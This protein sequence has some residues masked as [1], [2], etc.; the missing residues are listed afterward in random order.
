M[1]CCAHILNLIVQDDL[2]VIG[3]AI[4]KICDN[5][6]YWTTSPTREQIFDEATHQLSI[7]STKKLALD[8]KTC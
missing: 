4:A 8:C 1:C 3:E 5:V 6:A 7:Q 2:L